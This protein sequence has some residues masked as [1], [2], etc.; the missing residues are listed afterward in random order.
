MLCQKCFKKNATITITQIVNNEQK[1][2]SLCEECAEK[3]GFHQAISHLPQ[4]FTGLMLDI[5]K[6]KEKQSSLPVRHAESGRCPAC[7]LRWDDFKRTGLLGCDQCYFT[8]HNQL[9]DVLK[10]IHG[11]TKHIGRQ[12][13][14]KEELNLSQNLAFLQRALQEAIAKEE[15]EKAAEFRDKIRSLKQKLKRGE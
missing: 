1:E 14:L 4:I 5:L 3:M 13:G 12:P 11:N 10:R 9:K 8:F 6:Y 7:G 2:L 15:Y